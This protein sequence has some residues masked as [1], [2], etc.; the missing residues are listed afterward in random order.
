M[1]LLVLVGALVWAVGFRGDGKP[2]DEATDAPSASVPSGGGGPVVDI[3]EAPSIDGRG[4]TGG[5]AFT[6][7]YAGVRKG[8]FYRMRIAPSEADVA[9]AQVTTV[10]KMPYKAPAKAGVQ[11]CAQVAVS[12]STGNTSAYSPIKCVTGG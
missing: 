9:K 6:W 11:V 8:D 12:R 4:V 2:T 10:P 5:V 3:P 1:L 7:E